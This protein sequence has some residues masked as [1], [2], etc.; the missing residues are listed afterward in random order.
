M[1]LEAGLSKV[2]EVCRSEVSAE[3]LHLQ[4]VVAEIGMRCLPASVEGAGA[5]GAMVARWSQGFDPPLL[6]TGLA[7]AFTAPST[8]RNLALTFASW[9]LVITLVLGKVSAL[10]VLPHAAH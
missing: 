8:P 1:A 10:G 2:L 3:C 5:C 7:I 4:A 9:R 6:K